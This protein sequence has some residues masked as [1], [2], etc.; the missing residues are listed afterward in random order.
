MYFISICLH[1]CCIYFPF[2][3]T[4][5]KGT[6]LADQVEQEIHICAVYVSLEV[7]VLFKDI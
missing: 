4:N 3:L 5:Y 1:N 6:G 7:W 2:F